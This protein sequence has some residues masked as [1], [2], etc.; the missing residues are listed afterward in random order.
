MAVVP[1]KI[2][3]NAYVDK[4]Q[5]FKENKGKSGIYRW[6]NLVN[7]SFYIGSAVDLTKRLKKILWFLSFN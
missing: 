4:P 1:V 5:I 3:E 7:G 2:Y 6:T